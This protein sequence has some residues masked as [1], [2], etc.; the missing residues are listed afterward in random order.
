MWR[1]LGWACECMQSAW[2]ALPRLVRHPCQQK[3]AQRGILLVA[4]TRRFGGLH[5]TSLALNER[6]N[7]L[8]PAL[9]KFRGAL[10]SFGDGGSSP[11]RFGPTWR[12]CGGVLAERT[13]PGPEASRR[14]SRTPPGFAFRSGDEVVSCRVLRAAGGEPEEWAWTEL[15]AWLRDEAREGGGRWLGRRERAHYFAFPR[16]NF[17]PLY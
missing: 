6:E 11:L 14:L 7:I 3:C 15:R 12:F 5:R 8:C 17:M 16:R 2:K 13:A 9:L 4:R 1:R 10:G